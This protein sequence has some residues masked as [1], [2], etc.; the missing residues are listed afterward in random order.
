MIGTNLHCTR[1]DRPSPFVVSQRALKSGGLTGAKN[2]SGEPVPETGDRRDCQ[3][4]SGK[5]RRKSMAVSS[6]PGGAVFHEVSRAEGPSQ[7]SRKTTLGEWWGG[8][9]GPLADTTTSA[10]CG[11]PAGRRGRPARTRG[12]APPSAQSAWPLGFSWD[13]AGRRPIQTGQEACPTLAAR[14]YGAVH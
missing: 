14:Y 5:R 9:P 8:P 11:A 10:S 2:Q 4:I 12:S 7:Q 13:F 3:R 6:V 1:W